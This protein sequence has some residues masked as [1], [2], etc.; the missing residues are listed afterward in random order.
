MGGAGWE[1]KK[2]DAKKKYGVL[3]FVVFKYGK[4]ATMGEWENG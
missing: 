4:H 2:S 3:R 1:C